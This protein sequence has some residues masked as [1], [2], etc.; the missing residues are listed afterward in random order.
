MRLYLL[1]HGEAANG[2]NDYARPLT[3][4]GRQQVNDQLIFSGPK[5]FYDA[6]WVSPYVRAVQTAK[7]WSEAL[8]VAPRSTDLI[9]PNANIQLFYDELNVQQVNSLMVVAHNPFLSRLVMDFCGNPQ[10]FL[11]MD[12]ASL[13]ALE[14]DYAA[15]GLGEL[16]WVSHVNNLR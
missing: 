12:T 5:I 6:L 10:Q 11:G 15:S 13:V 8:D 2:G 16:L 14:Y 1:R 9:V 3:D 7:I 4:K